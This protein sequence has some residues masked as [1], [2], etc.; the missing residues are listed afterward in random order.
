M[1]APVHAVEIA[2]AALKPLVFGEGFP[3]A[4]RM[5]SC[6]ACADG[7][8]AVTA[9]AD[10]ERDGDV[11]I[12]VEP[13]ALVEA[14]D[15][16]QDLTSSGGAVAL[17]RFGP[18]ARHLVEVLEVARAKPPRT[19]LAHAAIGEDLRQGANEIAGDFDCAI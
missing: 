8:H 5:P 1:E 15:L 4:M 3:H 18:S 7:H 6:A 10:R 19:G 17:H 14:A 9:L 16:E 11:E 2:P 13:V 12:S